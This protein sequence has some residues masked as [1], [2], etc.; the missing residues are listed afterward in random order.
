MNRKRCAALTLLLLV[1]LLGSM[2]VGPAAA[3]ASNG[4]VWQMGICLDGS[5]SIDAGEWNIMLSGL[6][7]AVGDPALVPQD[8]TVELTVVQFAGRNPEDPANYA[9]LEVGPVVID[10]GNVATI[11][12]QIGSI[13]QGGG[14]TPLAAG[15][16]LL[17]QTMKYEADGSTVRGNWTDADWHAINIST[18]GL[19]NRPVDT[20]TAKDAAEAAAANAVAEGIDEIDAE[21]VGFQPSDLQWMAGQ[22][23]GS[24]GIVYPTPGVIVP[25]E[26]Y[27]P[28]PPSGDFKGF[29]RACADFEDYSD[30]IKEKFIVFRSLVLEPGE[31]T[32]PLRTSHTVTATLTRLGTPLEGEEI[33]FEVISGP[34]AGKNSGPTNPVTDAAGQCQWSYTDD[35]AQAGEVDTIQCWN[36]FSGHTVESNVVGKLWVAVP[37]QLVLT[38]ESEE[39]CLGTN[40][41]VTATV[42]DVNGDPI[43][44]V[45]VDFLVTSGPNAG[46]SGQALTNALGQAHWSYTD[47]AAEDGEMD[48]IQASTT[49]D[50]TVLY[51][52]EVTKT[53][54]RC[55]A[56]GLPGM[57]TWGMLV[58]VIALLALA[59]PMLQRRVSLYASR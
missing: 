23:A 28:R 43:A 17:V 42:T 44:D 51:S 57:G 20:A 16:D 7:D 56:P 24:D 27:P 10:A 59:V 11:V 35:S 18:D 39:N 1:M 49:Y 2:L 30:A 15:I 31:W 46:S 13:P 45:P 3:L 5:G 25:P 9:T 47:I 58:T 40:H 26:P 36:S 21:G 50:S 19:P 41:T 4:V 34:N 32:N 29:V 52:N 6:Q 33:Y 12:A 8:G 54:I 37:D 53:W 48:T 14:V 38:P 55:Q 22:Q